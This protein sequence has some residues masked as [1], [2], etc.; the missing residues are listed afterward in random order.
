V[1]VASQRLKG[2]TTKSLAVVITSFFGS[3]SEL[4]D[5]KSSISGSGDEDWGFFVFLEGVTGSNACNPVVVTFEVTDKG[6]FG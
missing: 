3:T 2:N 6:K 4:P 5:H 1:V